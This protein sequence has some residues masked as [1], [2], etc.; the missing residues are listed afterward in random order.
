MGKLIEGRWLTDDEL[1]EW[2]TQQ[3]AEANGRFVRGVAK[4]R[5]WVTPNGE[6]GPSGEAGFKAEAD[7]YH[8]F[9][10]LNC[11]WAHRTLIYRKVK[12][13]ENVIGLS[14]VAPLRT[15]QG[16]VFDRESPRFTDSL[17]GLDAM[18]QLYVKSN[19]DFTGRVTVP[20]LWDKK[21]QTIVSN[22]SSEII[23]M[24]NSAFNE[25]TG[26][27]QDF[28]AEALV[29]QIDETNDWIFN[30]VNNG[31]YKAGF[32]RTQEAYD[33]AVTVLFDSLETIEERLGK[34]PF[35]LGDA[36]TEADWR[37]LPTL[38]R[39][40]V[41][42]FTAFKCNLKALRDYPNISAYLKVL[43]QQPGVRDTIDVDV[44]RRGYNSKSPM[45]NPHGIVPVA[46]YVSF[47][48]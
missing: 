5:N 1:R 45:R 4:F 41:G 28:C 36:I 6:A 30:T 12:G 43:V 19:P 42:Y 15:E 9:A 37:L 10:A 33:E 44:Y 21:T 34:Q 38:V 18:H 22:E 47:M 40:D 25:I 2:E 35:L 3:Y 14:L 31:V 17:L 13:L 8:L 32:A 46:P 39:F 26:D 11:P 16:W 27:T 48:D 29:D 7:R 23:R 24:F 20:V